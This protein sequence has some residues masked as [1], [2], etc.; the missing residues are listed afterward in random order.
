M[1]T[2]W[3]EERRDI[4]MLVVGNFNSAVQRERMPW[5]GRLA[6]LSRRCNVVMRTGVFGENYRRL[7]ARSR[8]VFQCQQ[9][10]QGRPSRL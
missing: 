6:R 3:P 5:L 8:I 7:L 1:E 2:T 10:A 9:P 4:D